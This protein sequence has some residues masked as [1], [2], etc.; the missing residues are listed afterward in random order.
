[1]RTLKE[2]YEGALIEVDK[3]GAPSFHL[4]EFNYYVNEA[5]SEVIDDLYIAFETN[6]KV[7][8]YLKSGKKTEEISA[9]TPGVYPD[10]LVFAL[11]D[12]YRH[13]TNLIIYYRVD[14]PIF[15][16]CYETDDI[17]T[18]GSARISSDTYASIIS[19]PFQRPR[20]KRPYHIITDSRCFILTGSHP[21][22]EVEKVTLDYL[23]EPER[24]VLTQQQAFQDTQ[25]TSQLLEFDKITNRKVLD[26]LVMKL[27][28][29]FQSPRLNTQPVIQQIAPQIDAMPPQ[30]Q[31]Q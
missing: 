23:K 5:M 24:L 2:L 28:E 25:D 19:D 21:S 17:I 29:K 13:L 4:R 12:D 15:D 6:Q 30:M 31:Q 10:S 16:D 7:L 20:F 9:F 14:K 22:L 26:K 3:V 18:Y 27:L 1:M 11:P 8:D